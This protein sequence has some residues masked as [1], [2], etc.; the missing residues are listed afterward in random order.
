VIRRRRVSIEHFPSSFFFHGFFQVHWLVTSL[1]SLLDH[2]ISN[3]RL[4]ESISMAP[5]GG[6]A[7]DLAQG[8][9]LIP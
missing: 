6:Q 9:L 5:G 4:P 7:G 3:W 2:V 8:I 1:F